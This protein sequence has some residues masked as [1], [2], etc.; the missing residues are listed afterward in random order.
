[1]TKEKETTF[2]GAELD[3]IDVAR[4]NQEMARRIAG[5]NSASRAALIR[6]AIQRTYPLPQEAVE[7]V[8]AGMPA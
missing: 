8:S 7:N 5:G 3:R 1:M 2:Y 4:L 6:E